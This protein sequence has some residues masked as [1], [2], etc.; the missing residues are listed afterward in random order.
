MKRALL[1]LLLYLQ[2]SLAW[3]GCSVGALPFQLQNN[4][5]AD[6]TQ[7]MANFNQITTG[8]Q[9]NCAAAG[10]NNDITSLSALST[11]LSPAQ[12]GTSIFYGAVASG[13]NAVTISTTSPPWSL[14][15]GNHVLFYAGATS[16]GPATLNIAATGIKNVFR[17]TQSGTQ[18]TQGGEMVVG[19]PYL[20]LYDGAEYILE[21]ELVIV[22]EMKDYTNGTPP[23]G[24][25]IA[26]GTTYNQTAFPQLFNIIGT[27]FGAGGAGTFNVP[28][29]RGRVLVGL[30][31]YGTAIG[32]A[33][34]LTNASTGCGV[35]VN[36]PGVGCTNANQSHLQ[37][38]AEVAA[39]THGITEPNSGTGHSHTINGTDGAGG[40]VTG[41]TGSI[42]NPGAA[43][44]GVFS[45]LS[46]ANATT[47]ITINNSPAAVA[48][49]IVNPNLGVVKIIRF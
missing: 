15:A 27:Q 47:G 24:W 7:V 9:V 17:R 48:M 30:D 36:V 34:R 38:A 26:D 21:G 37:V 25:L 28:D 29:T 5:V 35:L 16:T 11:P 8:T 41:T 39:H 32:A 31:N 22:G 20:A 40:N 10:A 49:P 42:R 6:A 3:A 2:A 44:G 13:T 1:A 43:N 4:T 14:V 45:T 33:N 12:G 18:V 23:P 19:N 46:I